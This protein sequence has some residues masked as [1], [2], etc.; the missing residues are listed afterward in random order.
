VKDEAKDTGLPELLLA[1][2]ATSIVLGL[3]WDISWHISIGRDTFW[4]PAHICIYA[5]GVLGGCVGG[6]LAF[7]HTF[8][9][10]AS[11][12]AS[13]RV[14]GLRAPL[15]AWISMWG[16][17]AMVTSAPFDDWWHNAYGLDVKIVSPP[18]A[19]LGLGMFGISLGA[20]LLAVARQNRAVGRPAGN[21]D[22]FRQSERQSGGARMAPYPLPSPPGEEGRN[23]PPIALEMAVH[24][25]DA[26]SESVEALP[27]TEGEYRYDKVE[28]PLSLRY[29]AAGK[30]QDKVEISQ[31]PHARTLH[32][33]YARTLF[34]YAGGIFV[35]FAAVF[36]TEYT[37][38]N[39]QHAAFFYHAC[40]VMIPVRL[41]ALGRAGRITWPATRIAAV[42]MV[43][44]CLMIWILP[45]FPAQPKLAPIYS[46]VTHMVP[47]AF[48]LLLIFPAVATD[49][50]LRRTEGW[51]KGWWKHL[52]LAAGLG[53]IFLAVFMV[54]Q[55]FF[56]EFMLSRHAKNWFFAGD[57][58]F[59]YGAG[60]GDWRTHFWHVNPANPDADF[61][62]ARK[63]LVAWAL[64]SAASWVGLVWGGWMRKVQR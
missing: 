25:S 3:I 60:S 5:G 55:W 16:A 59:G 31:A 26:R 30:V 22:G 2:G 39:Y 47:P 52:A 58:S 45:L 53:A 24:G 34:V 64:A 19:V 33:P 1:L 40:A 54:V 49:F 27:E 62:N 41:V 7:K 28:D 56:A 13:V 18:H 63:V 46:Q 23:H 48:P 12:A 6:W 17:L 36:I 8:L 10:P 32:A 42:Y 51:L 14:F 57:R 50:M 37:F 11:S 21:L 44:V 43:F 29:G 9:I 61:L 20:V 38:P 4:T 15:G 35:L